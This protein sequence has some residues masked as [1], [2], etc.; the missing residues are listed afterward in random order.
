MTL[1]GSLHEPQ[2]DQELT[3]DRRP[4]VLVI[5]GHYLPGFRAGG[6]TTCVA[7]IV[8]SLHHEFR[9]L[10]IARDRDLGTANPYPGVRYGQWEP[11]GGAHVQYVRADRHAS[12]EVWR[13]MA[14][15][16]HDILYLNSFFEPLVVRTLMR[17]WGRRN[18][19]RPALLVPHG[20]FAWPSLSQKFVKKALF[21]WLARWTGLYA[22]VWW[23]ASNAVEADDVR[24]WMKVT[25]ARVRIAH[26]LPPSPDIALAATDTPA[27][28]RK[29]T[30]VRA[31]FFARVAPEK[32][33]HVALEILR[34]VN[35]PVTFD[36]IGPV[37]NLPYWKRCEELIAQ[38]PAHVTARSVGPVEAT[39]LLPT[40]ARYDV[41]LFPTGGEGYGQVIA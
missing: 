35:V 22:N 32:N 27:A 26:Q 30:E 23:H 9:F 19:R 5:V 36:I 29:A 24:K 11:V 31:F 4:V 7:N 39:D 28:F 33:L 38:L 1:P 25:G 40:L 37:E 8:A 20:E 18:G 21:I 17:Q 13:I 34:K 3:V 15:T 6:I 10:I 14:N 2:P 16:A 12:A 41:M